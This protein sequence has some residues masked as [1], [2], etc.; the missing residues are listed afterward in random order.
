MDHDGWPLLT[1]DNLLR[2]AHA[3]AE[4]SSADAVALKASLVVILTEIISYGGMHR[5]HFLMPAVIRT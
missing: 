3:V 4:E 2:H 5:G 1:L